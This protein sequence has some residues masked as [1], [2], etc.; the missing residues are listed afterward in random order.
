MPQPQRLF[1]PPEGPTAHRSGPA[2]HAISKG[3]SGPEIEIRTSTRRRRTSTAFW[4]RSRIV[5][6]LPEHLRGAARDQ[7]VDWLVAQ[8]M[9]HRPGVRASDADLFDRASFLAARYVPGA[10][11]SSVRWVTNQNS[12]WGSCNSSSREIRVSHRLRSVPGWVLDAVLIHELAH[13]VHPNHSEDFH[14]LSSSFSRQTDAS[15][16]LEGYALGLEVAGDGPAG[17]V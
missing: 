15:K 6:V 5:V 10:K 3:G 13:L 1:E 4:H 12:R 2:R 16:F 14:R 11:P 17:S 8:V 7:T 9:A